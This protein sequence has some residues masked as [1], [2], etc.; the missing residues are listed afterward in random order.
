MTPQKAAQEI[1]IGL[2]DDYMVIASSAM[3]ETVSTVC[4]VRCRLA[5]QIRITRPDLVV[6][7]YD[8]S[9]TPDVIDKD[10]KLLAGNKRKYNRYPIRKKTQKSQKEY[11]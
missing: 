8:A 4:H 3:P 7:V 1:K 5:Q 2:K 9:V 6:G 10:L 11:V